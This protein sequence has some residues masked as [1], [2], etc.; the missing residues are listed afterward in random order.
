[1]NTVRVACE[2]GTAATFTE[3][4]IKGVWIVSVRG[5]EQ[6]PGTQRWRHPMRCDRCRLSVPLDNPDLYGPIL[7]RLAQVDSPAVHRVSPTTVEVS[8]KL[9]ADALGAS[10]RLPE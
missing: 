6:V 8:L 1:M 5:A 4:S 9:M 7:D 10:R 3:S 2:H